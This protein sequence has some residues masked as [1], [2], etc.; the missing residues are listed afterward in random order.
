MGYKFKPSKAVK[1]RFR[2]TATG[3]LKHEHS[4]RTHLQS[5]R[6]SKLRMRLRGTEV[7]FEGHSRNMRKL[8]GI[9]GTNPVR[10]AHERRVAEV[11]DN[12]A[13]AE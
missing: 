2:V 9:H 11:A 13:V 10:I 8:M 4:F 5:S 3:K 7:L 1:K 6:S 12:K